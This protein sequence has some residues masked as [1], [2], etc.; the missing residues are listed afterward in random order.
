MI[1]YLKVW[2]VVLPLICLIGCF[3]EQDNSI[4]NEKTYCMDCVSGQENV[5]PV[6][7]IGSGPAGL[8]AALYVSRA[9]MK[10][11]VFAGPMPCGQLTQTTFIENWPGRDRV[12]GATLMYDIKNQAI[13]FGA[14]IIHDTIT[15]INVDKWP[16][17]IQTEEGRS[18]KA[19]SII[20]ATGATPKLLNVAGEKEY[21]GK[22]VTTCAI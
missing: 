18:F 3:K 17:V 16:F 9:G 15:N 7:I 12:L 10:S 22:G 19:L 20:L 2:V 6:A 11:F 4:K 8:S 14:M 5:V 1:R 13:S 21:W